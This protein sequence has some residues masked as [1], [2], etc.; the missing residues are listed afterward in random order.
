MA[1]PEVCLRTLEDFGMS[2]KKHKPEEV[3]AELRQ[4]TIS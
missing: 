2:Q 4:V 1:L 3:A